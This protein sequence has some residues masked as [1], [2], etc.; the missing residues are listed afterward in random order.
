MTAPAAPHEV[1]AGEVDDSDRSATPFYLQPSLAANRVAS[2]VLV[3]YDASLLPIFALTK[4]GAAL[5][6]FT[7]SRRAC[8]FRPITA[9]AEGRSS[10]ARTTPRYKPQPH[11]LAA[12]SA[13]RRSHAPERSRRQS[14]GSHDP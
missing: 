3:A 10:R 12:A 4:R 2:V 1:K 8:S 7:A 6:D 14:E 9:V 13:R 11:V 5:P